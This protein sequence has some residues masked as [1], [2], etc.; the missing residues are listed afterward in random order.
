MVICTEDP[1]ACNLVIS[2]VGRIKTCRKATVSIIQI[3]QEKHQLILE[4][5]ANRG[6]LMVVTEEQNEVLRHLCVYPVLLHVEA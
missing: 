3:L 6:S 1:F 2:N 5:Q 4:R